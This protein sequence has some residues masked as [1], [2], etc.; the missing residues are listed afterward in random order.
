LKSG[1]PHFIKQFRLL[2]TLLLSVFHC[3]M[4]PNLVQDLT[5]PGCGEIH[6][7]GR[8]NLLSRLIRIRYKPVFTTIQALHISVKSHN[9]RNTTTRATLLIPNP[10]PFR[11]NIR[12]AL[13]NPRKSANSFPQFDLRLLLSIFPKG[14]HFL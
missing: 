14:Q 4:F 2:G 13:L 6:L 1:T 12:Y 9:L 7:P 10:D 5:I 11:R 8:F 3:L